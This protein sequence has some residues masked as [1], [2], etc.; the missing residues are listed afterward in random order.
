MTD[1]ATLNAD[2]KTGILLKRSRNR[3]ALA[4]MTGVKWQDRNISVS[5]TRIAYGNVGGPAKD[6]LPLNSRTTCYEW[7]GDETKE[8]A[9]CVTSGADELILNAS[10]E[11]ER[12]SWMEA[13]ESVSGPSNDAVADALSDK[14]EATALSALTPTMP[15]M[16][17]MASSV[18]SDGAA[19]AAAKAAA[20]L[21]AKEAKA[22]AAKAAMHAKLQVPIICKK[23]TSSESSYVD[24]YI[25]VDAEKKEF[26]WGKTDDVAKGKSISIAS[27]VKSVSLDV[28]IKDP[29]FH[30]DLQ[31]HDS[32]F[33]GMFSTVPVSIDITLNDSEICAGFISYINE[34]K[35]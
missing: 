8:F 24:R 21:A 23:K 10:S 14:M 5:E 1:A 12:K 3:S 33:T 15:S 26:F 7:N 31:N 27:M 17:S 32:V 13:I 4:A 20:E 11:E 34:L 30:I 29:N 2:I 6:F 16:M 18:V 28:A 22:A 35:A 25:W 19:A 9:F